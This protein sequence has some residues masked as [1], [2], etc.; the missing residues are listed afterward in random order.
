MTEKDRETER[1]TRAAARLRVEKLIAALQDNITLEDAQ[2]IA[3][4]LAR[5]DPFNPRITPVLM[6]LLRNEYLPREAR[7]LPG[8]PKRNIRADEPLIELAR[9]EEAKQDVVNALVDFLKKEED[10][11]SLYKSV[12]GMRDA[13]KALGGIGHITPEVTDV[14]KEA[15]REG[16]YIVR[17][18]AVR[19]LRES[20]SL[21]EGG[22]R[23]AVKEGAEAL[24]EK[25]LADLKTGFALVKEAEVAKLDL[26]RLRLIIPEMIPALEKALEDYDEQLRLRTPGQQ[27]IPAQKLRRVSKIS[28][29]FKWL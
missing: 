14:L 11:T 28:R 29:L 18:E 23:A 7:G 10:K 5:L 16:D 4:E 21:D 1:L 17:E 20:G 27:A 9:K 6:G 8:I 12:N 24:V 13:V 25:Y 15:L 2:K 22:L 19:V 3:M 26:E